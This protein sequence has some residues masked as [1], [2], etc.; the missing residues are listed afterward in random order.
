MGTGNTAP[1]GAELRSPDFF[2]RLVDKAYTL[3]K[4]KCNAFLRLDV[5][6]LE[7]RS[8]LV[9]I[10]KTPLEPHHHALHVQPKGDDRDSTCDAGVVRHKRAAFVC[11]GNTCGAMQS[12]LQSF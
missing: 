12:L 1:D 5:L 8:V 9:L 4:V 10:A 11:T 7:E 2:L 6:D 3:S